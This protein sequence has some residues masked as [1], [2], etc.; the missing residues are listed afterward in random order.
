MNWF[1]TDIKM[2]VA[3]DI[4]DITPVTWP[5]VHLGREARVFSSDC[6]NLG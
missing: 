2:D 1:D 4:A 6:K 5:D 3:F